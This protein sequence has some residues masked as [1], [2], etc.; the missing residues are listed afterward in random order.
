[1]MDFGRL[2]RNFFVVLS[3]AACMDASGDVRLPRLIGDGLVLQRDAPV[4]IWG[5]ASAGERVIVRLCDSTYHASTDSNGEWMVALG[6]FHAGGPY[7]MQ[8]V[9]RNALTVHDVMIGDVW[10]CSGQSNM[11]LSMDRVSPAYGREIADARNPMIRQFLVPQKYDFKGA[12][13]DFASGTWKSA[14]SV[15]VLDFSAAGYFFARAL[16]EKYRIPIGLINTSLG[17]SPA[18]SWMSESALSAFPSYLS[19]AVRFRDSALI[20]RI[21]TDDAERIGE[22]YRILRARDSG[23]ARAGKTWLDPATSA[24]GWE[25]MPVPGY[26]ASTP[27]GEVNGVVWFARDFRVPS[28]MVGRGAKCVLGRIVDADSTFINGVFIGTTSYQYPPRQY[29]VPAG[30]LRRGGNRIVVRVISN[31]GRGGFVPDKQYS[32]DAGGASVDLAGPWRYRLGASMPPLAG[33]T[34]IRWKPLGLYNAMIAPLLNFRIRGAVWY[35]GESNASRAA[36]YR[37]LFPAMIRDWRRGWGQGDFPFLFVQLPNFMEPKREPSE[38]SWAVLREAQCAALAE[39]NTGMAV[40]V[41]IGEWND[42]HPLDKKDV[43]VRLALAAERVAYQDTTV[44]A[45]GPLFQSMRKEGSRIILKFSDAGTGLVARG[46]GGTLRGFAVAGTNRIFLW[47]HA[48]IE[49]NEVVV[50][51]DEVPHPVAVRYAWA[52][53]PEGA[54]LYNREGLPASPFRTDDWPVR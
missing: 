9:G 35:Q 31:A 42:I 22:W 33:Q 6:P 12:E 21:D 39:P 24:S 3:L 13:H 51:D 5:W 29:V 45:S 41:D 43:G 14:D 48:T 23:Y 18:E 53:N 11:E 54:N 52:D 20:R 30:L 44:V 38:G 28:A 46:E 2:P 27:L 16:Y 25:T 37:T 50:R 8:I 36:E 4:R 47:A 17:G 15:S 40:T 7:E 10:V 32:I 49:G 26:W 34:F 19:E 1:M